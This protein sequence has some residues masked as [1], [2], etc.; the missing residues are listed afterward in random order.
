MYGISLLVNTYVKLKKNLLLRRLLT[1][2]SLDVLVKASSFILLPLYLRLMSQEQY[3]SF[4]YILSIVYSFSLVLNLGLYIPQSKL[5]HD[6]TNPEERG[7]LL[8]NINVILI[9]GL[10]VLVLPVYL[11]KLDYHAVRF[12]FRNSIQYNQYRLWIL[13]MSIV[14]LFAYMLTNYL[15]TAEK[16]SVIKKYSLLRVGGINIISILA[17][18]L[19]RRGDAVLIRL[20][21]ISTVEFL[22]LLYFYSGYI[23]VMIPAFSR[24]F[25]TRCLRIALPIMVS[26]I[27]NIIINFGDKFFLEKYVDYKLLSIYYLAFSCVSVIGILSN[28]L[29]NVWLPIFFKEKD[30]NK[31]IGKTNKMVLRLVGILMLLS[32]VILVSV[33]I[34]LKLKIIPASYGEVLYVLPM[35]LIGQIVICL[36]LLYGNYLTYFEKTSM[37]LW[38]GLMISAISVGLNMTLIPIWKIYGAATTSLISNICYLIVYYFIIQ[39]YRKKKNVFEQSLDDPYPDAMPIQVR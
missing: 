6:Y 26:A 17:L 7:K 25:L 27:F 29:Q 3:G 22:L 11:F 21:T 32:I 12:L 14:A 38:T 18:Y 28:S 36:A 9:A 16:I 5:Y 4:N 34:F 2:L 24:Y 30:L 19:F 39:Y 37:V 23:R 33:I 10:A 8:Y 15:Y 13:L 20:V 1:V 31:N 35:L